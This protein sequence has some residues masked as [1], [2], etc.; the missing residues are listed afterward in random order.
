MAA[1]AGRTAQAHFQIAVLQ[2]SAPNLQTCDEARLHDPTFGLSLRYES[3]PDDGG[4]DPTLGLTHRYE[5]GSSGEDSNPTV[6]VTQTYESAER[7]ERF[8][9]AEEDRR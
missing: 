6:G 5:S 1:P 7:N 8:S 4:S 2:M 9:A 3:E